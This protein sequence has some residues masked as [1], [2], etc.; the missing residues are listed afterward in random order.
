VIA[1]EADPAGGVWGVMTEHD[2][3]LPPLDNLLQHRAWVSA[4]ARRLLRD[5]QAAE[6]LAQEAWLRA[7][8][9]PPDP[10]RDP[11]PWLRRVLKNLASNARRGA[12]R[13]AH[14]ESAAGER[15]L[16]AEA[17]VKSPAVLVA[18]A[19][20]HRRLVG[21]ILDLEEPFKTVLVLR[22]YEGLRP[23]EIAQRTDT[24]VGTVHSRLSR[25]V[26]R[27]KARLDAEE[28]GDR[29]AWI[30]GLLPL[31]DARDLLPAAAGAGTAATTAGVLMMLTKSKAAW[32]TL[33]LAGCLIGG[34]LYL[35]SAS[36][37]D[38][39]DD[40][41]HALL[42]ADAPAK[43]PELEARGTLRTADATEGAAA[44]A[45]AHAA[46]TEG[47]APKPG[48]HGTVTDAEGRPV[49]GATVF[50]LPHEAAGISDDRIGDPRF[51]RTFTDEQGR[52][53]VTPGAMDRPRLIAW[54]D[55]ALPASVTLAGRDPAEPVAL[56]L[57]APRLIT[58]DVD[59]S[60]L[61]GP[62]D[63]GFRV[64]TK[65]GGFDH[66]DDP[67]T[68][69]IWM[70]LDVNE[71]EPDE[72]IALD[73]NTLAPLEVEVSP[74]RGFA[75]M[76]MRR[77]LAPEE[78]RAA[79]RIVPSAIIRY[80]LIDAA[81]DLPLAPDVRTTLFLFERGTRQVVASMSTGD[82]RFEV[83]TALPPGEYHYE[84][85]AAGYEPIEAHLAIRTPGEVVTGTLKLTPRAER[86]PSRI[87]LRVRQPQEASPAV[88]LMA[89]TGAGQDA[90]RVFV[91]LLRNQRESRWIDTHALLQADGRVVVAPSVL[92]AKDVRFEEGVY[93]LYVARRD[94]G[95][96]ALRK[97]VRVFED[98]DNAFD[99]D[100]EP[101][102]FLRLG[103][104]AGTDEALRAVEVRA[105]ASG[106]LPY[107]EFR[108][109]GY[110]T[111]VHRHEVTR[112]LAPPRKNLVLG[113]F[114]A[115]SVEVRVIPQKGAA[116]TLTVRGA[117]QV[118][119][120]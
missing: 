97:G 92:S 32:L 108:S 20:Q 33:L 64:R 50:L 104:V 67:K 96:A 31:V 7:L 37:G 11:K 46:P 30:A 77:T 116:R 114:P 61:S 38:G 35:A 2:R 17:L 40:R 16:P 22:F 66:T 9:S 103:D 105:G 1:R 86:R 110:A 94:T 117:S 70:A 26:G 18:E 68:Q 49:H 65:D 102:T 56:V 47:V 3:P 91:V 73:V 85:Q 63:I 48:W 25:A 84:F 23:S 62:E 13:R 19:E 52:F 98:Q 106:P 99:V 109:S 88:T 101:G 55:E 36:S 51:G 42:G 80:K 119:K 118:A 89:Q 87:L 82:P 58:L 14:H 21:H 60:A 39:G 27:L 29:N 44:S 15:A 53:R 54:S 100:L 8:R 113:P 5:E 6:D 34:G 59:L 75:S 78:T 74:P 71:A 115:A 28:G 76:P 43:G 72:E 57:G 81:T 10:A 69:G 79:F 93:D 112:M 107:I 111:F 95:M 90:G 41:S 120:K 4:V 45:P 24:A 83:L 12:G